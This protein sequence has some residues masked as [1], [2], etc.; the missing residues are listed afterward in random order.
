MKLQKHL[1]SILRAYC[2]A[3]SVLLKGAI[4]L[5]PREPKIALTFDDGPDERWTP[6]IC[7]VLGEYGARASFFMIGSNLE[8][9]PE[10][11]KKAADLGHDPCAHLYS[12]DRAVAKDDGLFEEELTK[13]I[14]LIEQAVGQRP[15]FFRFPFAYPGRQKPDLILNRFGVKTVHWS[16][17]S[18][19]SRFRSKQIVQR[20]ERYMFPGSIILLHDGVGGFS[21]LSCNRDATLEALPKI[22]D[23]CKRKGLEPVPLSELLQSARKD[24]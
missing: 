15:V 22:L 14:E 23:A 1:F 13:T 11:A 7:S 18:L 24:S 2:Q 20:V 3:R 10:L 6:K 8:K 4:T 19:D 17:S 9:S 21:R 5:G 12:H 16:I